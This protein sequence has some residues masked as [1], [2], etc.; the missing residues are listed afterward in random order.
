MKEAIL[1]RKTGRPKWVQCTACAR[2]CIIPPGGIGFC[3]IRKNIDGK[4]YL[5]VYGKLISAAIDPIEKKPMMHFYPGSMVL[6][7]A[8]NGCN[9]MCKYCQNFSISQRRVVEGV[10]T[11][12]ENLVKA[13]IERGVD[14][15]AY[16]YN[17]PT[18][19]I[20]FAHDVGVLARKKGLYNMFV[21]NGYQS[22]EAFDLLK[23]FL[24]AAT[25]DF[26]GNGDP[27]FLYKYAGVR[28]VEP[29]YQSLL[30]MKKHGM[31]IEITNLVIPKVGSDLNQARK[32]VR[33]IV[34]NLGPE[35]PVHFLRFHPDYLMTNIPPTPVE[36]LEKH[37]EIAK[38]EGLKYVYIGNVPGHKYEH[39][40]CPNCG[41]IVI[42]RYGFFIREWNI[43][44]NNRCKF[45]G[46]KINIRG[47]LSSNWRN[48][49]FF[50]IP[51]SEL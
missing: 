21:T 40:Y 5:L 41:R 45:C 2:Y 7:I 47:K 14:G 38:E 31:F 22:E 37:I 33:W 26:K 39:T 4:L 13:A 42:K 17:E 25:V 15:F 35:T 44:E 51:M 19:F 32:L 30:M 34:E 1:Y 10:D 8:T 28:D 27:K 24:D 18:I 9:W 16:T 29:I 48:Y 11:T 36:T 43:D 20:E 49:R 12:P 3:G 23:H 50:G 6:S 46:Y